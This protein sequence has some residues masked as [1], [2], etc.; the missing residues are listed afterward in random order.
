[1]IMGMG[2]VFFGLQLMK[3][4]LEPLR[5]S[6]SFVALF[7]KFDPKDYGGVIRCVLVGALVTAVVQ[8]SSAT[9][10]IT[11]TL[12]RTGVIGFDTAVALVLGENIGTTITAFLSSLGASTNAKRVAYAHILIKVVAVSIMVPVF[13][14]YMRLLGLI[15]SGELDVAKRIAF[16]HTVFNVF[17]V[18]LFLPLT[19]VLAAVL[20]RLAPD[21]PHRETPHLTFLDVLMLDTPAFGVQQSL[22]EVKRMGV[23]VSKMLSWLRT[24]ITATKRDEELEKKIF[25]RENVLDIMQME[26]VEFLGSLMAGTLPHEVVDRG[27]QAASHSR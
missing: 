14:P 22:D 8:S 6:E 9:V 1:M 17:L 12:A 11:I 21:K 3:D 10:A 7:S 16:S 13:F 25:H 20:D 2:M 15:L 4:G 24:A 26:I 27:P 5:H 23:S 19:G 18:C